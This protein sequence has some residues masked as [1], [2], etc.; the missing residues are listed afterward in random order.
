MIK[1]NLNKILFIINS[2]LLLVML[3]SY[4]VSF[5]DPT[6]LWQISLLG[7]IFPFILA[8]NIL[9]AIYWLFSWKKYFWANLIIILFGMSHIDN[10]IANQK[11]KLSSKEFNEIKKSKKHQFDQL[12]NFMTYN[13]RLFNQNENINDNNVENDIIEII[14][15][16]NPNILCLQEFNLTDRTKEIFDFYNFKSSDDNKLQIFT[17]YNVFNEG[18]VESINSCLY[19]DIILNDTIRV[20][21][22]HLQSNLYVLSYVV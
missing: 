18:F 15:N 1:K 13:V 11:N 17:K 22:I 8:F 7:I 6:Y 4:T 12:I 2:L 9:F 3:V 21:N 14:K 5:I 20:Y 16:K 10:I 19:K